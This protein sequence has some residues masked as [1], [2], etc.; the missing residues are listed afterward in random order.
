[1]KKFCLVLLAITL[2]AMC[3]FAAAA[4][5]ITEEWASAPVITKAYEQSLEKIYLEWEGKA[6]VYQVYVDGNKV[7]DTTVSRCVLDIKKGAHTILVYPI[8]EIRNADTTMSVNVD[9]SVVGGGISID[10]AAL[11]LDPKRMVPGTPSEK[12]SID[13]KPSQIITG[14]PENISAYTDPENRV[15]LSFEDPY[16]SDEYLFTIKR[17]NNTNYLTFRRNGEEEKELLSESGSMVS[18]ILDQKYL[19]EN[20]CMIPEINEEY[21]F[22]VQFRKYA[23]DYVNG[24]KEASIVNDSKVSSEYT[25]RLVPIWKTAP[26]ITFASQTADGQITLNWDHEDYGAGCQYI[27]MKINKTFGVMTGE[28]SL[29]VTSEHEYVVNELNNGGYCINIVPTLNGE[30]G[31]YSTDANIEIKNEW[32]M[33]PS[34]ECEQISKNEVKL[35]WKAPGNIDKYHIDIFRGNN[36]SLLRFVDMDYSKY[37]EYNIEAT[38]GEMEFVFTYDEAIDPENGIKLK[39]EIYGIR[40]A[41]GE[42]KSAT[43]SKTIVLK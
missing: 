36:E 39:F 14:K 40:N 18:V 20:E 19:R 13:Y 10:L 27:V 22:T 1:M 8:N 12:L 32:V 42:Q 6:P 5:G 30:K 4:E 21:K 17:G 11:G 38:E 24:T 16:F 26:V 31:T 2:L 7:A 34:L 41:S 28:E 35:T 37:K 29:G 3:F 9:A 43:S 15:V 33:A 23:S 25:Y